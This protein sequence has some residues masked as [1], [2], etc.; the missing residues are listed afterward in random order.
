PESDREP[1]HPDGDGARSQTGSEEIAEERGRRRRT[2]GFA[3]A[4]A[5]PRGRELREISRDAG[6]GGQETPNEDAAGEHAPAVGSIGQP[7]ER[8]P[9]DG[10]QE[11]EDGGEQAER[12]VA[13]APLAPD[14]FADAANEL[15]VEEVHQV[16]REEDR[17]PVDRRRRDAPDGRGRPRRGGRGRKGKAPP[18]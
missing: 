9:D 2:G 18:P 3:D 5:E 10:V 4:D 7:A 13:Q 17:Q 8:Q 16:D 12:R 1:E 14:A 11:R 15:A 6:R